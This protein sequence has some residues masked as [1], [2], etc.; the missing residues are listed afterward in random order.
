MISVQDI[1]LGRSSAAPIQASLPHTTPRPSA[2][3]S[4]TKPQSSPLQ[5]SNPLCIYDCIIGN[6]VSAC[7]LIF[8]K[9]FSTKHTQAQCVSKRSV[10]HLFGLK[11]KSPLCSQSFST[12]EDLSNLTKLFVL[13]TALFLLLFCSPEV[14][15]RL[16]LHSC[17][18]RVFPNVS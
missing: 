17:S 4:F 11:R 3:Q 9:T 16:S 1:F 12:L 7:S 14:L 13:I 15:Y 10:C 5:A 6:K 18:E 2:H 8:L